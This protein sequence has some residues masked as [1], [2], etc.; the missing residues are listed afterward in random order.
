MVAHPGVA[1]VAA[2]SLASLAM[3]VDLRVDRRL[4]FFA[5]VLASTTSASSS[6]GSAVF[7]FSSSDSRGEVWSEAPEKD[8]KDKNVKELRKENVPSSSYSEVTT[9]LALPLPFEGLALDLE[10]GGSSTSGA[11]LFLVLVEERVFLAL[12]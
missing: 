5:G 11:A 9:C 1:L 7:G 2:A 6:S 8:K 10:G 3:A 12:G 4:D